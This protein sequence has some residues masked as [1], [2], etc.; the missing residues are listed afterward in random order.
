MNVRN[1]ADAD[2]VQDLLYTIYLLV[3]AVRRLLAVQDRPVEPING[4][5][6]AFQPVPQVR[7]IR[8]PVQIRREVLQGH[9]EAGEHHHGH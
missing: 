9:S 8:A 1:I 3:M 6:E 4:A 2:A 7:D 5:H